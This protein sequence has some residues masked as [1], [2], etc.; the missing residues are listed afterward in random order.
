M[1]GGMASVA[2]RGRPPGSGRVFGGSAV[3]PPEAKGDPQ[4][5]HGGG[6]GG[7]GGRA[8]SGESSRS[9]A[10]SFAPCA[11]VSPVLFLFFGFVQEMNEC[12]I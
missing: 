7:G 4:N 12:L 5:S 9:L 10:P 8:Y 1:N 11:I 6:G 2:V 3:A